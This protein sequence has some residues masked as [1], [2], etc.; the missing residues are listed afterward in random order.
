MLLIVCFPKMKKKVNFS[1][2][3]AGNFRSTF[4][5]VEIISIIITTLCTSHLYLKISTLKKSNAALIFAVG[6]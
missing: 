3:A 4:H 5:L 2:V 6:C 1:E